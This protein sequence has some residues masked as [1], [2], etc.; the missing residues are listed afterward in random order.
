MTCGPVEIQWLPADGPVAYGSV[1]LASEPPASMYTKPTLLGGAVLVIHAFAHS[2][3]FVS[4][5]IGSGPGVAG[6]SGMQVTPFVRLR[7]TR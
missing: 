5:H 1:L 4:R 6:L 7:R 3:A 2:I